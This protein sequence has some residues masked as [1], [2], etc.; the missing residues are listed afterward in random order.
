MH[1][2]H[3]ELIRDQYWEQVFPSELPYTVAAE[4]FREEHPE[5]STAKVEIPVNEAMTSNLSSVK[6]NEMMVSVFSRII[7]D[8]IQCFVLN[9]MK[10]MLAA[11]ILLREM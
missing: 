8:P 11:F 3:P 9:S 7:K 4:K 6:I 1:H 10:I 5:S 2:E